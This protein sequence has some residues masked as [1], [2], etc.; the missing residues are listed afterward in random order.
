MNNS[1]SLQ[2]VKMTPAEDRYLSSEVIQMAP[3]LLSKE[4]YYN[5]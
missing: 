5:I 1:D 3:L 4:R 2:S